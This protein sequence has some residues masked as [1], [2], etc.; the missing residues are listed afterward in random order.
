MKKLLVLL[1]AAMM[2]LSVA[3]VSM[4]AATVGGELKMIYATEDKDGTPDEAKW[5]DKVEA[6]ITATTQVSD[7]VTGFVA[8]KGNNAG[9]SPAWDEY[10]ITIA[11]DYGSFKFGYFGH[12]L[13]PSL[14]IIKGNDVKELKSNAL[15]VG[16][17]NIA[18]GFTLGLAYALDGNGK[19]V[20]DD[21][22]PVTPKVYVVESG[23]DFNALY[24]GS[25]DVSLGY[26]TDLFGG[27][28]HHFA[29]GD[30][31]VQGEIESVTALDAW[32]QALDMLKVYVAYVDTKF[33]KVAKDPDAAIIVGAY[34]DFTDAFYGR[35]EYN[36]EEYGAKPNEYNNY[37]VKL[38]YK[39]ANGIT[40]E[41]KAEKD[42]K[43][44]TKK[45][46]SMK[47]AL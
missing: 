39:L 47:V 26:A 18:D 25:Y 1:L 14:D 35:F 8:L 42:S 30:N 17:F 37:G 12:K 40:A 20:D 4:A 36:I 13:T 28:V 34:A 16:K 45:E 15:A 33:Y 24:D 41:F 5:T 2:V 29:N 9:A 7:S 22:N 10:H 19:L 43:D 23:G 46:L 31:K 32:Y 27:E 21:N 6:K 3:A 11:Q 44:T 38:G